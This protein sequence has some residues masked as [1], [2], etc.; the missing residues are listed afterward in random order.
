MIGSA[1]VVDSDSIKF[2]VTTRVVTELGWTVV[3]ASTFEEANRRDA[4]DQTISLLIADVR[5]GAFNGVHLAFRVRRRRPNV[6]I[7]IT[8]DVYD[9]TLDAEAKRLGGF[10]CIKPLTAR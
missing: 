1:L 9:P 4:A 7:I 5:L 10:Y 3:P 2:A 8:H 6:L